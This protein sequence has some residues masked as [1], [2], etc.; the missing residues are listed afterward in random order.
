MS[1]RKGKLVAM[2]IG[3]NDIRYGQDD[4]YNKFSEYQ[5]VKLSGKIEI[6]GDFDPFEKYWHM[7]LRKKRIKR[8]RKRR[9]K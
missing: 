8:A 3:G 9:L 4:I 1:V 7:P 2:V 6:E 5:K